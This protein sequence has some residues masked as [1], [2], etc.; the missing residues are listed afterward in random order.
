MICGVE[1]DATRNSITLSFVFNK[2]DKCKVIFPSVVLLFSL[3]TRTIIITGIL[4]VKSEYIY[5]YIYMTLR[6]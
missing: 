4:P 5:I 2:L 1:T 6:H 3:S